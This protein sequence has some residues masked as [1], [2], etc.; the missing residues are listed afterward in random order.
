[1]KR[2]KDKFYIKQIFECI[3]DGE[4]YA[5]GKIAQEVGL[6]EKSVRNKLNEMNE[7][8]LQN[9][10][11]EIQRKPRVGVWLEASTE[12]KEQIQT[13]R[14]IYILYQQCWEKIVDLL[15]QHVWFFRQNRN[16][17]RSYYN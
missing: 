9:N 4:V 14:I 5:T 3:M 15:E 1:M 8:L 11:G 16:K 10:L 13:I 7:F 12:K 17:M 2:S 6:S